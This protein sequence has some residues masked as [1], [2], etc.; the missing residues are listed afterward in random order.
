MTPNEQKLQYG[1]TTINY[2]VIRSG[3][4]RKT[5]EI[6]VKKD[7]TVVVRAPFDKPVSDIEGFIQKKC[8]MGFKKT[9]RVQE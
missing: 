6:I 9:V 8:K 1:N 3:R 7:G 2:T 4:R 5:S